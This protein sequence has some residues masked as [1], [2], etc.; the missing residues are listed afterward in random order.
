[1]KPLLALLMPFAAAVFAM[2]TQAASLERQH[3][4]HVH[5]QATG[6][7]AKDSGR[8]NLSLVVPGMNLVGFE[9]A[10]RD[11]AQRGRLSEVQHFLESGTWLAFHPHGECRIEQLELAAPG[12][13]AADAYD[14]GDDHDH[15]HHEHAE[16]HLE[17]DITCEQPE[18]LEWLEL[19][20]FEDY[21]ANEEIRMDVLTETH[22]ERL[23]LT[24]SDAR[25]RLQ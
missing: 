17:L 20:L 7:L 24:A 25:I 12:F 4:A 10:P 15:N 16:F 14:H 21:P 13:G 1:M 9:H 19:K 8:L 11:E 18:R 6:T 23:R 3:G 2:T 22:A 5:G